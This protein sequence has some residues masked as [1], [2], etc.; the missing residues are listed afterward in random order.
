MGITQQVKATGLPELFDATLNAVRV[1]QDNT[2][3]FTNFVDFD[4]SYGHRRNVAGYAAALEYIDA[5][6]PELYPLLN[7][8]D[9]VVLT[10]DHGCDPTW[11]GT[12]HTREHVPVLL[13]GK[14]IS[15]RNLGARKTFADIGQTL[16]SYFGTTPMNY[17]TNLL[18][19]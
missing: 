3:V 19:G 10:A 8:N 12:D 7:E 4:S 11:R 5:R 9:I 18:E 1:A 14:K 16:A 15:P 17:G 6:L 2:I 13:Y